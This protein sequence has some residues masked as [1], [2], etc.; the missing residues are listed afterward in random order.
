MS[1]T[2]FVHLVE[3]MGGDLAVVNSAKV[4]LMRSTSEVNESGE[5]LIRR[6]M[7]DRHGSTFEHSV[8]T[9]YIRCPIFVAREW[10]RHRIG[11]FNEASA[12]Y[13]ELPTNFYKPKNFRKPIDETKQMDYRYENASEMNNE[14]AHAIVDGLHE[15]VRES[16]ESLLALGI[17]KEHARIVLPVSTYTEFRWT[18]NARSLMNFLS[19]RT[20]VTAM[21]EIRAY[22]LVIEKLWSD[23]MPIT[24]AAFNANNR[25][26]P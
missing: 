1:D 9:F 12:R 4:S 25:V 18:I 26:A 20:H 7:R 19:L 23:I 2:A 17:A 21:A 24:A 3:S 15:A 5:R 11:S 22:A 14:M 13:I 10:F 16:Y 8:M 6:L